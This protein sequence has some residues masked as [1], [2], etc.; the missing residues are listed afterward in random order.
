MKADIRNNG[1]LSQDADPRFSA[2]LN[3]SQDDSGLYAY[4][5]LRAADILIQHLEE[6]G[7]GVHVVLHPIVFLC[8]HHL[9]LKLKSVTEDAANLLDA[10]L[11]EEERRVLNTSHELPKL[12]VIAKKY[13]EQVWP[14]GP[15]EDLISITTL[16][17]EIEA[18]DPKSFVSRYPTDNKTGEKHFEGVVPLNILHFRKRIDE[19]V[20][21][22]S[23]AEMGIS[24]YQN[25]KNEAEYEMQLAA[26]EYN[27]G[28]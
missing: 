15:K 28:Y 26:A 9:E 8:R 2:C 24:E 20:I 14:E 7:R 19:A 22:L 27:Y 4:G 11:S 1:L 3:Y 12:W 5:Y 18:I 23:G 17:S 13:I 25:Y 6:N 10:K 16:L 21:L